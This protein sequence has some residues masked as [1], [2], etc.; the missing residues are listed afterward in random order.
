MKSSDVRHASAA[1][2]RLRRWFGS[3]RRIALGAA[4]ALVAGGMT[5]VTATAAF[6]AVSC[7]VT[8]Q[9][10]WEGG[11]GFGGTFTINNLAGSDNLT[12]WTL[13]FSFAGSQNQQ[14]GNGWNGVWTQSGQNVTVTNAP[15]N[16][17]LPAAPSP[18]PV[19]PLTR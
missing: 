12:S 11:N 13:R 5:A 4:V 8:Y 14:V 3:R 18:R 6:A 7:Q 10:N 1:E 16:G 9:K 2:S 19:R 17:N 15:Y